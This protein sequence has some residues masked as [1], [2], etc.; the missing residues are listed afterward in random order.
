VPEGL[1]AIVTIALALGVRRMAA[2]H[3][4][5]RKLTAV[6]T[7]GCTTVICTDKT[8]TLTTGVMAVR[9]LW[10]PDHRRVL[11]VAASCCDAELGGVGDP[12]ELAILEAAARHGI[13]RATTELLRPRV[14]VM[15]FDPD[16]KRMSILRADGVL[17]VEGAVEEIVA[18]CAEA[19]PGASDEATRMA[20]RGLRVLAIATGEGPGEA[21]LTLAGLIGLADPPRVEAAGAVADAR[22]AGIQTVMITGDHPA[23]ARAIARELGL[24]EA[25]VHARAM[26]EDKLRIVRDWKARG[27]VVAM[28]GTA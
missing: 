2:R 21:D 13:T 22:A 20:M 10:G 1:P 26:P 24:D 28:T 16:R 5:V 15:P 25:L 3:A 12:T 9:A 4:L 19:A 18:R 8:G 23:T 11:E 6:E 17:Y 14:D 27:A 7:L